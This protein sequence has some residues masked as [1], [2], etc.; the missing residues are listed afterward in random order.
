MSNRFK[1]HKGILLSVLAAIF[2][3]MASVL[4]CAAHCAM[5]SQK[6]IPL[7]HQP[8][9]T[10]INWE[11]CKNIYTLSMK[12]TGEDTD[13]A[14]YLKIAGRSKKVFPLLEEKAG[15]FVMDAYNYQDIDG[16]GTPLYTMNTLSYPKEIDPN[17]QSICV[18]KNYFNYNPVQAANGEALA[19]QIIYDDFTLNLL[20]PEKYK[21]KEKQIIQAYRKHFYF[22]K[23][24]AA[25]KYNQMAGRAETLDIPADSLR[26]HIL[27]VKD[28]QRYFT[29]RDD[30][31]VKTGNYITDPIVKIYTSNI[32][33][34]YAHSYLSQWSY[35]YAEK[36]GE[37][38]AYQKL[39]PYL[40]QCHAEKSIQ[41]VFSVYRS[42]FGQHNIDPK[43]N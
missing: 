33:C 21:A 40:A 16:E 5:T 18:S 9:L 26:I 31:A 8:V 4:Y 7:P 12:N 29:F 34:N 13:T 23:V 6:E 38:E 19:P 24:I 30:C 15:V 2:L 11:Q 39:F 36:G 25:N 28:G 22:Q 10:E 3:V 35:F 20:V 42:H 37:K 32:H 1:K 43:R 27:Y 17:G 41:K 14:T